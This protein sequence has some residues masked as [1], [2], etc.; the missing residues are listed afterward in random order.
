MSASAPSTLPVHLRPIPVEIPALMN[1][2]IFPDS[3]TPDFEIP[4]SC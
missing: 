4:R 2:L 1:P 3:K